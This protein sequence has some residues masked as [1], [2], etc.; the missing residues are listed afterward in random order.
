MAVEQYTYWSVTINNPDE[1]DYLIVRNPNSKY[2]REMVWTPEVGGEEGTPHIQGWVRLQR[3]Q[4]QAFM[5]KLYPRAHL[6][7]CRKDDYNENCFRYAQKNDETTA[8]NHHIVLNDPLPAS[9]T[10]LYQVL[11]R[12]WDWLV[13]TDK[14]IADFLMHEGVYDVIQRLNLK[15]LRTDATERIMISEKSGLEKIFVSPVYEKM[16]SKYWR[17][18]L[19]RLKHKQDALDNSSGETR[20]QASGTEG[21]ESDCDQESEASDSLGS[22]EGGSVSGGTSD[23]FEESR[24]QVNRKFS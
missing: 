21:E 14:N 19:Y 8:G 1:N 5:K 11:E 24:E 13:E 3:N 10:I 7:P 23:D 22:S 9:D 2:I 16:K 18:I 4:S 15:Q 6:K 17:E 12:S 20:T